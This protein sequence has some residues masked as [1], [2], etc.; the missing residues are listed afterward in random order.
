LKIWSDV[1]YVYRCL[2]DQQRTLAFREAIR[3]NVIPGDVVLDLGTGSGIMA[4]FAAEADA[5]KIYAVEIGEYLARA[6][7]QTFAQSKYVERFTLLRTNA[8]DL[9][10]QDIESP[11]VVI[12]EMITTGLISEMQGPVINC[13]KRSKVIGPRTKIIPPMLHTD[14]TL[15]S[16]DLKIY[17]HALAFPFFLDYF[18]REL[19]R[20]C[21]PLSSVRRVHTVKFQEAFNG[22]I[23][24]V[25]EVQASK[26][27]TLNGIRLGSTTEFLDGSTLGTCISYCQ[28][29]ILPLKE[30]HLSEGAIVKV[31]LK[32]QMGGG[33]DS[34]EYGAEV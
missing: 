12:C 10:L 5:R 7:A 24:I 28:P 9:S 3:A 34:L 19:P 13:L 20:G 21:E 26:A 2:A 17:Q 16:A 11:D 22:D 30:V 15:V 33:F 14:L 27:G 6:A 25:E 4:L 18:T 29:V 32:Y 8:C 31:Y 23:E 1:E